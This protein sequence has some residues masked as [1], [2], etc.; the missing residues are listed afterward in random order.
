MNIIICLS[1]S[2]LGSNAIRLTVRQRMTENF[3][4][5]DVSFVFTLIRQFCTIKIFLA[6]PP[7]SEFR[8]DETK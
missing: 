7:L 1:F 3:D 2:Y 6:V 4:I 8:L 5:H